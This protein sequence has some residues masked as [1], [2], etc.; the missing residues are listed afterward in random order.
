MSQTLSPCL[1]S[2]ML[3]LIGK[4]REV[5]AG[6]GFD[7]ASA[8]K[9]L[10]EFCSDETLRSCILAADPTPTTPYHRRVF[11][12]Q[13]GGWSLVGLAWKPGASTH[14]HDH[15]RIGFARTLSGKVDSIQFRWKG[16][17]VECLGRSSLSDGKVHRIPKGS[18]Y[19]HA[20]AAAGDGISVDL[21]F[22]GPVAKGDQPFRYD[23]VEDS[24]K[25]ATLA[26]GTFTRITR[27]VDPA[28]C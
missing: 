2:A 28:Q 8:M 6:N 14:I 27:R 9:L 22:Y 17:E 26:K 19:L 11:W 15:S 23:P 13:P 5:E 10:G 24:V 21:H 18:S 20:V 12:E 16:D 1:S 25:V 7:E 3:A 4:C